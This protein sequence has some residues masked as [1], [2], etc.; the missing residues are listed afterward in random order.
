VKI[1]AAQI[2]SIE[3]EVEK[4]LEK[5]YAYI[6]RAYRKGVKLL[7]FPELS[8]TGYTRDR[9]VELAFTANDERLH[10]LK[11]MS[12]TYEMTLVVGV[13][14]LLKGNLYIGSVIIQPKDKLSF[15][16]KQFLHKGE[17]SYYCASFDFN[18]IIKLGDERIAFS[19]CADITHLVHA[20]N[21]FNSSITLYLASIFFTDDG[22]NN[23]FELLRNYAETFNFKVLMSNYSGRCAGFESGGKSAFWNDKGELVNC[24]DLEEELL[25]VDS[26]HY[27][28]ARPCL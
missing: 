8:I 6:E 7:L 27:L 14:I 17:E 24:L 5:H 21:A 9:A 11:K 1:A 18:P 12:S 15:Y 22:M 20:Q 10:E 19:I 23:A 13:P 2:N 3:G 16:T 28:L 26:D 4:N 25:V